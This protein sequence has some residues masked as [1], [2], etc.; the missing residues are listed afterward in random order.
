MFK[1][2]RNLFGS[3]IT[4]E[5]QR[6]K[7]KAWREFDEV[8]SCATQSLA[9]A[10][11]E[12]LKAKVLAEI[13]EIILQARAIGKPPGQV[14]KERIDE[15]NARRE[16]ERQLLNDGI[17]MSF[18]E[19]SRIIIP[20]L[21]R[22]PQSPIFNFSED[23]AK[24]L[25]YFAGANTYAGQRDARDGLAWK[26]H[27]VII[28]A[29]R[30]LRQN[31][32]R[33]NAGAS[34]GK[35]IKIHVRDKCCLS[36]F[37]GKTTQA[38]ELLDAY[39]NQ[40]SEFPVFPPPEAPCLLD[41][42]AWK[43]C[44]VFMTPEYGHADTTIPCN[45]RDTLIGRSRNRLIDQLAEA[46]AELEHYGESIRDAHSAIGSAPDVRCLS[47]LGISVLRDMQR[48]YGVRGH[49]K[50]VDIANQMLAHEQASEEIRNI[51]TA[52]QES[53]L[54]RAKADAMACFEQVQWI[55]RRLW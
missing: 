3:S 45:W 24:N 2:L 4:P 52:W 38:A 51:A 43:A 11:R 55:R 48:R 17:P 46:E 1:W 54:N 50:I 21:M 34:L 36:L 29:A 40:N 10:Q 30:S 42:G 12:K 32:E 25:F 41:D 13:D 27:D 8:T 49:R 35:S 33:L 28:Q 14:D 20:I 53:E 23:E 9:N 15:E 6:Y 31:Y 39:T 18:D 47:Q 16:E 7:D 44:N 26:Q 5:E 37:N 22:Y 19:F